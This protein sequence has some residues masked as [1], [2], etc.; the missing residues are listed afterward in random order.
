MRGEGYRNIHFSSNRSGKPFIVVNCA[1]FHENILES[2][3]FGHEK[4]AFSGAGERKIG[5]FEAADGGTLFL[6]EI[7]DMP[8]D[9][10]EKILR[11]IEYQEFERV[12]G[13]EKIKVDVRMLAAAKLNLTKAADTLAFE[14]EHPGRIAWHPGTVDMTADDLVNRD[15]RQ[16][17]PAPARD[18]AE[19]WLDNLTLAAGPKGITAAEVEAAAAEAG[20]A[21]RTI[22]RCVTPLGIV[23]T[24]KGAFGGDWRWY[25]RDY[26]PAA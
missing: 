5:R 26:A 18:S 12:G 15:H 19:Q 25:A 9:F 11:V 6:D 22:Q 8:L 7:G 16:D 24:N 20:H 21:I 4:G 17:K 3:L 23:C 13:I 14:I 2:E 1:A 10:Q